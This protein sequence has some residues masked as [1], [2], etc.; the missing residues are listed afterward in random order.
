MKKPGVVRKRE[1]F[2]AA[3]EGAAGPA[4]SKR[5]YLKGRSEDLNLEEK[6]GKI[7]V[8]HGHAKGARMSSTSTYAP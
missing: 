7:Q 2:T 5:A 3:D 6:V 1:E 8:S 4:G